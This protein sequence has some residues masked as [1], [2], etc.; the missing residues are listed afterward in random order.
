MLCPTQMTFGANNTENIS[1]NPAVAP[2]KMTPKPKAASKG[3]GS[4]D[5]NR[6]VVKGS[7]TKEE[8]DK[9]VMLVTQYGAKRWS[10]IASHLE[11]RIS[12]QC[13]ERWHNQLNPNVR[14]DPWT[15]EEDQIILQQHRNHGNS[16]AEM[17]KMLV[18][19]TDNAIKNR[20]NA[21]LKRRLQ[22]ESEGGEGGDG[23]GAARKRPRAAGKKTKKVPEGFHPTRRW[24]NSGS[25]AGD[26]AGLRITLPHAAT[27]SY[28]VSSEGVRLTNREIDRL[29]E[30]HDDTLKFTAGLGGVS[31][32]GGHHQQAHLGSLGAMSAVGMKK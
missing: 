26:S 5:K 21:T 9:L 7:W 24:A 31:G 23:S 3:E 6:A 10:H 15:E 13:R 11:G 16:W 8:D 2:P 30:S 25:R 14:K 1:S 4:V 32:V 22:E 28:T 18:G 29:A 12:K 27:L 20:F 17:A 19:R